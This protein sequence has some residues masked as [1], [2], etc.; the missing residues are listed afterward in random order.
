MGISY[1]KCRSRLLRSS[2]SA[3]KKAEAAGAGIRLALITHNSNWSRICRMSFAIHGIFQ[4]AVSLQGLLCLAG[5]G[6]W[7]ESGADTRRKQEMCM[8]H[9]LFGHWN[10]SWRSPAARICG[11]L[12]PGQ[13]G[14]GNEVPPVRPIARRPT[15]QNYIVSK[16]LVRG[17]GRTKNCWRRDENVS[18]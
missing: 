10:R 16:S 1:K 12:W 7:G 14:P 6:C 15:I 9:V 17:S 18:W 3:K 4:G 11:D 5:R 2:S 8:R 13:V